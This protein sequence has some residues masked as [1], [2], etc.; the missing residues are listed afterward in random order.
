MI[1]NELVKSVSDIFMSSHKRRQAQYEDFLAFY[2]RI[3]EDTDTAVAK[4]VGTINVSVMAKLDTAKVERKEFGIILSPSDYMW[5]K[6][7]L[8]IDIDF[9]FSVEAVKT[10][11]IRSI[12]KAAEANDLTN[13]E[14][15]RLLSALDQA[16][17]PSSG[18][19]AK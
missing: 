18:S 13:D 15:R 4:V 9:V 11:I 16:A 7:H 17:S 5:W 2:K 10:H 19:P 14:R 8:G 6:Q 1:T 3:V 12:A